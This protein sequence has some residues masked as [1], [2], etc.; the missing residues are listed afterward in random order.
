MLLITGSISEIAP[1]VRNSE[2]NC[3]SVFSRQVSGRSTDKD[4]PLIV[5]WDYSILVVNLGKIH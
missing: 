5:T 2:R 3:A 1:K 4:V